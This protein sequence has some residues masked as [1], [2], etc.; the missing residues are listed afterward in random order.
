MDLEEKYKTCDD[1]D[2][3]YFPIIEDLKTD[4]LDPYFNWSAIKYKLETYYLS[5]GCHSWAPTFEI[6]LAQLVEPEEEWYVISSNKHST[7]IN[8]NG[9]KAFDLLYWCNEGR[10]ENYLF[11]DPLEKEDPTLGGKGAYFDSS[12]D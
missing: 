3:E 12:E 11:N 4:I 10:L 7:V 2:E 8:K 5:G 9:T 1:D 6:E